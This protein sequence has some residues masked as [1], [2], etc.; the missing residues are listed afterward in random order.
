MHKETLE[1]FEVLV[2]VRLYDTS[3]TGQQLAGNL[4]DVLMIQYK[5]TVKGWRVSTIDRAGTNKKCIDDVKRQTKATTTGALCD[6]AMGV[7]LL[8][9]SNMNLL[10]PYNREIL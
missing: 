3:L 7:S 8:K 10:L 2:S 1:I 5:L 6:L 9:M 4:L